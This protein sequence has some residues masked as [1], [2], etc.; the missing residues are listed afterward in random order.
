MNEEEYKEQKKAIEADIK[1]IYNL[2]WNKTKWQ[3]QVCLMFKSIH[4]GN[5]LNNEQ[6]L[7]LMNLMDYGFEH[8]YVEQDKTFEIIVKMW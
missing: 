8:F 2:K 4:V 6:L 3:G 1:N 5:K 7:G